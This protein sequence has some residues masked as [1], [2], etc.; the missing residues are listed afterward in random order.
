MIGG[1]LTFQGI[2]AKGHY[3]GLGADM[4]ASAAGLLREVTAA[5]A[6]KLGRRWIAMDCGKLAIYTAQR[7]LFAL[8]NTIGSPSATTTSRR[9]GGNPVGAAA[10]A[11][12]GC[13]TRSQSAAESATAAPRC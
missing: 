1:Y 5:T 4:E 11:G 2:E 3:A 13:A 10:P 9:G 12:A 7:R 6:E 8:T